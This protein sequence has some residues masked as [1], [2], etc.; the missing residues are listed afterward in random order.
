MSKKNREINV[1]IEEE[2]K[3][4]NGKMI[5]ISKLMIGKK[6]IGR[7]IPDE[8]KLSVEIDNKKEV[9]VKLFDEAVEYVIRQ[10]NLNE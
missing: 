10:W 8:D 3:Q 2:N 1:R 9:T 6:E 4:L 5:T 7:I